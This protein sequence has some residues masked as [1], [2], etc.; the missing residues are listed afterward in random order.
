MTQWTLEPVFDSYAAVTAISL[1]LAALLFIGPTFRRLTPRRRWTIVLVR[2]T[3]VLLILLALLRPTRI[4][5]TSRPQ[6]ATLIV[7]FDQSRSM[8][9]PHTTAG[10]NRWQAQCD[11]LQ[12][13]QEELKKLAGELQLKVF[14]YDRVVQPIDAGSG[15]LALPA[16]PTGQQTDIGSTL[17]DVVQRELGQ[18]IAA[19]VLLGDGAQTASA[20]RVEVQQAGRTL[21]RLESP[22]YTVAFGPPGDVTESRDLSVEN[23]PEQYTVFVQNELPVKGLVRVRGY[24]GQPLAVELVVEDPQGK[25]QTIGTVQVRASEDG[26][27]LPVEIPFAP[28]AAGQYK[29]T[30]RAPAQPGELVTS[31]NQLSAFV[32]VLEGGL[33][34]VYLYGDLLGEQR[35]LRRSI[36]ASPDMQ[37]DDAFVD[38]RNRDRWP[39]DLSRVLAAGTF[40]VILL[41][42][43]AATALGNTSLQTIATMVEQGKG[44]MMIGGFH[45][46]GAGGFAES[47]LAD[48]L[49]IE[50]GR[51]E[52]QE[53]DLRTPVSRDLHLWGELP[54]IPVRPHSILRLATE[55]ENLQA[56]RSLPA[57]DGANRWA[58]VKPRAQVL[59]E[60]PN[61]DPLLVAGE[62][63]KGRVL[64]FAS[65]GTHRWWQY[66]RQS[67]HR[68]FWRQVVLWL[69]RREDAAQ[70][71]VWITLTQRR[72]DPG[73]RVTFLAGAKS[74]AGD[75][76]ADAT[77]H[78]QL[79]LPDGSKKELTLIAD[80]GQASGTLGEL[81]Q[82][83]DYLIELQAVRGTEVIGVA[84]A[85][86]QILDR[87][88][89]L[90]NPAAN[91]DLLARLANLTKAAGGR[92]VAPEQVP[93]LLRELRERRPQMLVEVQSRWQLADTALDAWLFLLCIVGLLA[94]EWILRKRWGLV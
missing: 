25:S 63:G 74:P 27:Q 80:G 51:L 1:V 42:S 90:G 40:D 54:M 67:E 49:P 41:E 81:P 6:S 84:R 43:V 79:V 85:Q 29:L 26:Q 34:V 87:D 9:L 52:R 65:N 47:P 62:Y 14:G 69:A 7:M 8:Q 88:V 46:F 75:T 68:R 13:A 39:V 58:G 23:L 50:M 64:A 30:L 57:L 89:E 82:P 4:S 17:D 3:V 11:T 12:Q 15:R 21:A 44:L 31:N 76:I 70:N 37:L 48:V 2:G 72:F 83:G 71:D 38:P 22:L 55:A 94:G 16:A 91:Y 59:A 60:T 92:P 20:P 10:K 28:T 33:R 32:T 53:I 77:F 56:W 78:A 35:L 86:F 18:R 5:T 24:S 19:V 61:G 66:G 36:D 73:V 45:S 93:G